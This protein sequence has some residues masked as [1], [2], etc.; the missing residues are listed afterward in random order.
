MELNA[1]IDSALLPPNPQMFATESAQQTLDFIMPPSSVLPVQ[2]ARRLDV[3]RT[4][5]CGHCGVPS[6]V[7]AK[8]HQ[9][10]LRQARRD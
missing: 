3:P 1:Q 7:M 4:Q 10:C 9:C 2:R 5:G 8:G 6:A